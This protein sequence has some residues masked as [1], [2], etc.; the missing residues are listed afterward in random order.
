MT[1]RNWSSNN[2]VI[3]FFF[4]IDLKFAFYNDTNSLFSSYIYSTWTNSAFQW[5]PEQM[6]LF[7]SHCAFEWVA[8]IWDGSVKSKS[9]RSSLT[10]LSLKSR[11]FISKIN[12]IHQ[13]IFPDVCV[14]VWRTR[15][16]TWRINGLMTSLSL[17]VC[18]PS[19][20]DDVVGPLTFCAC[21]RVRIE[22][23]LCYFLE[24]RTLFVSS[25]KK[26]I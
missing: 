16:C 3:S 24:P 26:N 10:A 1:S 17:P 9:V 8:C 14:W 21:H 6:S 12:K 13:L 18:L 15:D 19:D 2:N 11:A 22:A 23:T 5:R 25:A 20:I 4:K 7:P